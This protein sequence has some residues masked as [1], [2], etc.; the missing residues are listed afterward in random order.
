MAGL[1][2]GCDDRHA[3]HPL[4]DVGHIV[5]AGVADKVAGAGQ[6]DVVLGSGVG[7]G[8]GTFGAGRDELQASVRDAELAAAVGYARS[9]GRRVNRGGAGRELGVQDRRATRRGVVAGGRDRVCGPGGE[10]SNEAKG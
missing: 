1:R 7:N 6:D 9:R 2:G 8:V 10:H 5:D 3:V 4:V